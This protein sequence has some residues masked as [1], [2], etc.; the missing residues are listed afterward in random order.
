[1][2]TMTTRQL[3][4]FNLAEERSSASDRTYPN[5]EMEFDV[6]AAETHK[7]Q[8]LSSPEIPPIWEHL[9]DFESPDH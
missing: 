1:M 3:T 7:Q 9:G 6:I 8:D 4:A 5:I 2:T